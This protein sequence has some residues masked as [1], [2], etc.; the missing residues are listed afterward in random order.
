MK[1][2][3]LSQALSAVWTDP[4]NTQKPDVLFVP[5]RTFIYLRRPYMTKRGFR[6]WRAKLRKRVSRGQ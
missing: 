6:R 3:Q 2:D 5:V 1:P 4:S